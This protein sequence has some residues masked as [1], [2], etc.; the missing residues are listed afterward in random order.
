MYIKKVLKINILRGIL[1]Q[2]Y[3]LFCMG[4][5]LKN[6]KYKKFNRLPIILFHLKLIYTLSPLSQSLI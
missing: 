3:F 6:N 1:C 2:K 5:A 4:F